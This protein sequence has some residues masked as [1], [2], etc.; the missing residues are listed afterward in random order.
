MIVL[1]DSS[2]D[3]GSTGAVKAWRGAIQV[4]SKAPC[5]SD[6]AELQL[7]LLVR[8]FDTDTRAIGIAI[9]DCNLHKFLKNC[10]RLANLQFRSL[11]SARATRSVAL[12]SLCRRDR[13]S[14]ESRRSSILTPDSQSPI[15]GSW[16]INFNFQGAAVVR[17]LHEQS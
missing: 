8:L 5:D 17:H 12:C 7:A 16:F 3:A 11:S 4:P 6:P 2:V 10:I 15:F 9:V 1:G 13:N 14:L